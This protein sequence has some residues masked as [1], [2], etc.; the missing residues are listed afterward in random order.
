MSFA[1]P[2][3]DDDE[4]AVWQEVSFSYS[5]VFAVILQNV[6]NENPSCVWDI[7]FGFFIIPGE[8]KRLMISLLRIVSKTSS[9]CSIVDRLG[10]T[11][12]FEA[13][14]L[15]RVF[16]FKIHFFHC[17]CTQSQKPTRG[18]HGSDKACS[19]GEE[20]TEGSQPG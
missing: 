13:S 19:T 9:S 14:N 1:Q 5:D 18:S 3:I 11:Y 16:L 10:I 6:G 20:N 17:I 8:V 4:L 12:T 15:Y 7:N 2:E